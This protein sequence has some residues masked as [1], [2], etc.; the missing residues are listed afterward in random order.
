MFL[1]SAVCGCSLWM[2]LLFAVPPSA[3]AAISV[4]HLSGIFVALDNTTAARSK[5]EWTEDLTAMKKLGIEFFV[6]R[7]VAS[8]CTSGPESPWR[9][10]CPPTSSACP[11]GGFYTWYPVSSSSTM[12]GACFPQGTTHAV[13]TIGTLLQVASEVNLGV[14]LGLGYPDTS[15][16]P[17]GMNSTVYYQKYAPKF[18]CLDTTS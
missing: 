6:V 7:S 18:F 5:A 8:G 3:A 13:D 17:A 2:A 16:I 9:A 4:P 11:L 15:M 14:H 1:T 12:P 10:A